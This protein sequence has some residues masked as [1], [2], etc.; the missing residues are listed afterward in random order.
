MCNKAH[1]AAVVG[2]QGEEHR[3]EKPKVLLVVSLGG[4]GRECDE[5]KVHCN[6]LF[7]QRTP[8]QHAVLSPSR[9]E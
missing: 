2:T 1:F 6:S 8:P 5:T 9:G 3:R 4:M 7:L